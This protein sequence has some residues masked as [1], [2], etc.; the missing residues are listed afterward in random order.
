MTDNNAG[1]ARELLRDA[2]TR[3]IEHVDNLADG[4]TEE[5]ATYRPTPQANSIAWL[6]WH[7][8]RVQDVQVCDIA[9]TGDVWT[10]GGD[11]FYTRDG[12]ELRRRG[13]KSGDRVERR[14]NGASRPVRVVIDTYWSCVLEEGGGVAC[15]PNE[16]T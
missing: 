15:V 12:D 4:L 2:F 7:S 10:G 8:A 1:A 5:V 3:L 9:G 6:V 11:D 16:R 14:V 13:R